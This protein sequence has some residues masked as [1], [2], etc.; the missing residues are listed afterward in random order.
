[1][2]KK[3]L[4]TCYIISLISP[5]SIIN[6]VLEELNAIP[7]QV[8][9]VCKV[10]SFK[11]HSQ[12]FL[13]MLFARVY[14]IS[15]S[16]LANFL[17]N[18]IEENFDEI[19]KDID[20]YSDIKKINFSITDIYKTLESKD[21]DKEMLGLIK[22]TIYMHFTQRIWHRFNEAKNI[23]NHFEIKISFKDSALEKYLHIRHD[24]VHR[25]GRKTEDIA[26]K[27]IID[28][29]ILGEVTE[30]AKELV[31]S[32]QNEYKRI[33]AKKEEKLE[34]QIPDIDL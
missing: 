15:E 4:C 1:M 34:L 32:I 30:A 16:F 26:T 14:A 22:Q 20:T 24:I 23:Y 28:Q 29:E 33:E 3:S 13:Q 21:F 18:Y 19:M 6:D 27:H 25:A 8:E 10:T 17:I 2:A 11:K 12:S 9:L 31:N 5:S 7:N